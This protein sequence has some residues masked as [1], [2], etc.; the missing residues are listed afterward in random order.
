MVWG[1]QKSTFYFPSCL[2]ETKQSFLTLFHILYFLN[3]VFFP[4][5]SPFGAQFSWTEWENF[6]KKYFNSDLSKCQVEWK[7]ITYLFL[8]MKCK[9][10]A[11]DFVPET[12]WVMALSKTALVY[13]SWLSWDMIF[14]QYNYTKI[15][16][17]N[18][19]VQ[20]ATLDNCSGDCGNLTISLNIYQ[21]IV[22]TDSYSR[23]WLM[24]KR[25]YIILQFVFLLWKVGYLDENQKLI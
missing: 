6:N 9:G 17:E 2:Q 16:E 24:T 23:H 18:Q 11:I 1:L 25:W 20:C 21:S 5:I 8:Q 19:K 3:L 22:T 10:R 12:V 15:P 13:T 4:G 7:G 14:G